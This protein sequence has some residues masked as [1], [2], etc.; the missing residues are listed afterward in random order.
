MKSNYPK[1]AVAL[2]SSIILSACGGGGGGDSSPAATPIN[3]S[4]QTSA[5]QATS[6]ST[7]NTTSSTNTN[8]STSTTN[9]TSPEDITPS[10]TTPIPPVSPEQP[11]SKPSSSLDSVPDDLKETVREAKRITLVD[12]NTG[13]KIRDL[14]VS[15]RPLGIVNEKLESGQL[16]RGINLTYSSAT[17]IY[18][19]K[20]F[21]LGNE[22]AAS[23]DYEGL[24]TRSENLPKGTVTYEG[25]SVGVDYTGKLS[26]TANFDEKTVEGSITDRNG[27]LTRDLTLEKT[28]MHSYQDENS[29]VTSFV[30][31]ATNFFDKDY[32]IGSFAGPNGE[33]VIGYL[34]KK[35]SKDIPDEEIQY[36]DLQLYEA[37]GGTRKE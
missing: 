7:T 11:I 24:A 36:K 5:S 27:L 4:A 18:D 2:L 37:F 19:N 9:T 22:S 13:E 23:A 16:F 6:N 33:E 26:L 14:Y 21:Y 10:E 8:K 35:A 34:G 29:D 31:R 20:W 1:L 12:R 28:T 15:D 25:D 30:G 17:G 3:T 32:Y